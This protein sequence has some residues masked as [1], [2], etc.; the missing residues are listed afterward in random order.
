MENEIQ[1]F[2]PCSVCT[3]ECPF[4]RLGHETKLMICLEAD[5][6][7]QRFYDELN[8]LKPSEFIRG[9]KHLYQWAQ[10]PIELPEKHQDWLISLNAHLSAHSN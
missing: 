3:L 1:K 5:N 8:K 9:N 10:K 7:K 2:N 4:H 6:I